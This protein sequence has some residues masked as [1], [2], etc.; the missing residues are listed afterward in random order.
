VRTISRE[1]DLRSL[2]PLH[3]LQLAVYILGMMFSASAA[4]TTFG[5]GLNGPVECQAA[6]ILCLVFY[7]GQKFLLY[8][9]LVER[10]Q[11]IPA[12]QTS[13]FRNWI[14]VSGL[15]IVI[16]GFSAVAA[17]SFMWKVADYESLTGECFIGLPARV[18]LPLLTY[19]ITV[20][21]LLTGVFLYYVKRYLQGSNLWAFFRDSD[22][23]D[24]L[25]IAQNNEGQIT[26]PQRRL[27]TI[28]RKTFWGCIL[29]MPS[30]I[31]N[32]VVLAIMKGH[33]AGWMCLTFCTLDG[34]FPSS[35]IS[36]CSCSSH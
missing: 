9:F 4:I 19:D 1:H 28:I 17:I 10:T 18:A 13:R 23:F 8:L 21:L 14:Y 36:P 26:L 6:V 12:R 22:R 31:A 11:V 27:K 5:V 20:N 7:L 34:T 15:V 29:I 2:K 24:S 35:S 16:A 30:T 33:Q 3:Y 25:Q 32:M